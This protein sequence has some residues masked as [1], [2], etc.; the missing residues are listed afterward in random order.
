MLYFH[1]WELS[2]NQSEIRSFREP[3]LS[4]LLLNCLSYDVIRFVLLVFGK[5]VIFLSP[6][7]LFLHEMA[8]HQVLYQT[9]FPY[10][11][12]SAKTT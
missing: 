6:K 7:G 3:L 8:K 1:V 10:C 5:D 9:C 11:V 4:D 12:V 2:S